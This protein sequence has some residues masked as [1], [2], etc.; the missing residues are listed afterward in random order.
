MVVAVAASVMLAVVEGKDP[1]YGE[2]RH[3]SWT[4]SESERGMY[5]GGRGG[6]WTE[7]PFGQG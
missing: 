6:A 7:D 5:V 2:E 3:Q 4:L 1:G